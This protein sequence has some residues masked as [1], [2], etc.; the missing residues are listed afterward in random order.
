MRQFEEIQR[1]KWINPGTKYPI[2][3]DV[4]TSNYVI[5]PDQISPVLKACDDRI[6]SL[7]EEVVF[8]NLL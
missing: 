3:K 4:Y 7:E 6:K 8:S 5:S 2:N 1:A